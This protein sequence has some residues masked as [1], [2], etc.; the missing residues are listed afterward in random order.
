MGRHAHW[1]EAHGVLG[2]SVMEEL[3][4][5]WFDVK[6]YTRVEPTTGVPQLIRVEPMVT[7]DGGFIPDQV[8]VFI[9]EESTIVDRNAAAVFLEQLGCTSV[10]D[11]LT[12]KKRVTH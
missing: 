4:R 11:I 3:P 9:D 8:V 10:A 6:W 1:A 12:W 7:E 5:K 2:S